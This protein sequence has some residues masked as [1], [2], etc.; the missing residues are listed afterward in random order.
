MLTEEKI[1]AF[2]KSILIEAVSLLY[3]RLIMSWIT[4]PSVGMSCLISQKMIL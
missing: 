3:R 1:K 4:K 2:P